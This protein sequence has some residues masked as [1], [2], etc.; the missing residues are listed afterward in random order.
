M[1]QFERPCVEMQFGAA[2]RS[3]VLA[4]VDRITDHRALQRDGAVGPELVLP[5]SEWLQLEPYRAS[6]R[7]TLVGENVER[8]ERCEALLPPSRRHHGVLTIPTPRC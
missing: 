5:S 2:L 1:R 4:T 7:G 6:L 3:L 8:G